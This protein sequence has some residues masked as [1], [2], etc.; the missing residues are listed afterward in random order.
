[1]TAKVDEAN[2]RLR[3]EVRTFEDRVAE[4]EAE[5][6]ELRVRLAREQGDPDQ[7]SVERQALPDALPVAQ[8]V[9][10][11]RAAHA[12]DDDGD[13]VADRVY[14]PIEPT[15]GR[16]RFVQ[17]A[18]RA[19]V[20][21]E[22]V[23]QAGAGDPQTLARVEIDPESLRD[24]F[25]S[26]LTGAHYTVWAPIDGDA[27]DLAPATAGDDAKLLVRVRLDDQLTG[28]TLRAERLVD[29]RAMVD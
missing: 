4:L 9:E 13:G 27:V 21:V 24:A 1:M 19:W 17:V 14:V 22:T 23:P 10:I 16:G 5:N 20:A 7:P 2:N 26:G 3:H 12:R 6:A 18:A 15:D 25:R 28:A 11:G 29:L 8:S